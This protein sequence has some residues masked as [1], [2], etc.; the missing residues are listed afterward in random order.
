MMAE[1]PKVIPDISDAA[2][3]KA[4]GRTW[5]EWK[6]WLD[7]RQ[8]HTLSHPEIVH[9]LGSAAGV[10]SSWWQQ[11]VAN[12]YEKLTGRRRTGQTRDRTFQVGVQQ[13]MACSVEEL[14]STMTTGA[15]LQAW[16]GEG[17][18]PVLTPNTR[19][20]LPD[21]TRGQVG[22]FVPQDRL[23]LSWHPPG[24]ERSSTIQIRLASSSR[25]RS[26]LRFHQERLPDEAAREAR[27]AYFR[28]AIRRLREIRD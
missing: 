18:P 14:W 28:E 1:S 20:E 3:A 25:Q 12:G 10:R 7:G 22:V 15:G 21:G 24:W 17:A 9:L 11:A 27:R 8:A 16:L 4:T 26:V 19:F 5:E 6:E 2:V 23:R 13:T